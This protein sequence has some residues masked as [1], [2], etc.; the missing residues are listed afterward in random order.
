MVDVPLNVDLTDAQRR[1]EFTPSQGI[2][3][4]FNET[5]RTLK[6]CVRYAR[7]LAQSLHVL[8]PLHA[9]VIDEESPFTVLPGTVFERLGVIVKVITVNGQDV[10]I[11]DTF[12]HDVVINVGEAN[13]LIE[14][15]I[16]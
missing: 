3:F 6:I 15:Y 12:G 13:R 4:I 1:Q 2:D 10:T 14:E 11:C 7:Y 16:G 5:K 8:E 9:P